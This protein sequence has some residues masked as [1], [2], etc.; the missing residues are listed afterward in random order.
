M[1]GGVAEY[2]VHREDERIVTFRLLDF[3]H[4]PFAGVRYQSSTGDP[5]LNRGIVPDDGWV[6]LAIPPGAKTVGISLYVS[7]QED[8]EPIQM[9]FRVEE[10][11]LGDSPAQ[12]QQRLVNLGVTTQVL[13]DQGSSEPNDLAA[14]AVARYRS[15]VGDDH[16]DDS[17]LLEQAAAVHDDEDEQGRR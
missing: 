13:E 17:D 11:A 2:V 10:K 4:E 15:V 16:L 12:K 3:D 14:L 6:T 8:E 9:E 7:G 1:T 5:D